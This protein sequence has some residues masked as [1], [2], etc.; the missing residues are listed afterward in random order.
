MF[1][2]SVPGVRTVVFDFQGFDYIRNPRK[3]QK[4]KSE[5]NIK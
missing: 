4:Q 5:K 3:M 1:I 2:I